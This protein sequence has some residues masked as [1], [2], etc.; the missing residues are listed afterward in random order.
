MIILKNATII[1]FNPALVKTGFDIAI[2]NSLIKEVGHD[3]QNK[4][5]ADRVLDLSGEI[6]YPGLVCSHNHFYSALS[7]GIMASIKPSS[8]FISILQNLWWRLDRVIDEEILQYSGLISSLDAIKS[9]T[10]AVIDHH[11][12]PNFIQGSLNC[13]KEG[14]L[15][16]GLRGLTCYED[17]ERNG[18]EQ[19]RAGIDENIAFAQSVDDE[20]KDITK[21]YLVESLIGA[22]APFTIPDEGLSLLS[23]IVKKTERGIHIHVA[24]DLYDQFHSHAKYKKDLL[25]R[26]DDFGLLNR[27]SIIV[28]GVHLFEN[29][30]KLLNHRD[31][32][33]VHNA[34]SNMNNGVG[35]NGNLDKIKNLALGTDGIG[36][37]MFEEFKF[38]YFKHKD[39]KG[40][41]WPD[42]YLQI[43]HQGNELLERNFN[44]KFGKVEAGYKADLVISDYNSPTP[45]HKDNIAGHMAFGMSSQNVKSVIINGK[46]VYENREFPFDVKTIYK[47]AEEVSKRLWKKMDKLKD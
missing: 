6:V 13:L 33:L 46:I 20:K 16:A 29:D 45:L 22:H 30:I 26:L 8:D 10:T 23:D 47:K 21:P 2:E 14:F 44:A 9:G 41:M 32:F 7:R 15:K 38:A 27:K 39:E 12:S 35:Y 3:L 34:R 18:L 42:D 5:C 31:C 40:S 24:E 36:S 11:S 17:T 43:L 4:Y 19:R 1:E 25:T 28:H 37:D